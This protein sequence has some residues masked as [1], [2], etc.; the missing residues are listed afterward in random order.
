MPKS[1]RMKNQNI[2]INQNKTIERNENVN[3]NHNETVIFEPITPHPQ[4]VAI[5]DLLTDIGG[6]EVTRP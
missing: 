6:D 3:H 2:N 1:G 5:G 4:Q